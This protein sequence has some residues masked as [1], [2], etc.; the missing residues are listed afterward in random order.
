MNRPKLA[1]CFDKRLYR[2]LLCARGHAAALGLTEIIDPEPLM[3]YVDAGA[4]E[5]LRD[6]EILITGWDAPLL[7]EAGLENLPKL[8]LVAHLGATLKAHHAPAVWQRGVRVS[9]AVEAHRPSGD[10]VHHRR[11]RLCRKAGPRAIAE[12]L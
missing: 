8:K 7:D 12:V 9:A 1:L 4:R 10:R 5:T 3:S 11:Y 2:E 6:V